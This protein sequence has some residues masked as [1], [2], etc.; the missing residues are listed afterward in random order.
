MAAQEFNKK[1]PVGS[2]FIYQ[3]NKILRGGRAVRTLDI[4]RDLTDSTVVEI[5]CEPHWVKIETLTPAG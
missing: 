1:Y 2:G 4:A 3:P 5:N